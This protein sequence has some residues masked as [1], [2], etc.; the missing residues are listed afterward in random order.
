MVYQYTSK[1]LCQSCWTLQNLKAAGLSALSS[2]FAGDI[3][4]LIETFCFCFGS[5]KGKKMS[6]AFLDSTDIQAD[7]DL[8]LLLSSSDNSGSI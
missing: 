3:E 5:V 1:Y 7:S 2:L 6:L 4:R 8:I